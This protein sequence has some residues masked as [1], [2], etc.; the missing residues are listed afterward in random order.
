MERFNM[1]AD[2]YRALLAGLRAAG[3]PGTVELIFGG[4]GDTPS[5]W[6]R[7]LTEV[8]E[9]GG[10]DELLTHPFMILPNAPAAEP[11][12]RAKW[13]LRGVKRRLSH[14][15]GARGLVEFVI[16]SSSY[17]RAEY[18]ELYILGKLLAALH[19]GGLT[20]FVSRYLRE[21]EGV[22]YDD[23][24]AG[25]LEGLF[26]SG[27]G[28]AAGL[29]AEAAGRIRTFVEGGEDA[30]EGFFLRAG[31]RSL[32]ACAEAYFLFELLRGRERFYAEL[33]AFLKARY[34]GAKALESV[35]AWQAS[36]MIGADYQ[37]GR[38]KPLEFDRD[39]PGYFAGSGTRPAPEPLAAPLKLRACDQ[40]L[41]GREAYPLDWQESGE[42]GWAQA[43][44]SGGA[45]GWA[46]RFYFKR[47][48]PA[49]RAR[50]LSGRIR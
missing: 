6:R 36:I 5:G 41:G 3:I 12:Y 2:K 39:W 35:L 33:G 31:G 11:A 8:M 23:F 42:A 1:G 20:L 34:P 13:G 4:P 10:H 25:L 7:S 24:Y 28:L 50:T 18:P 37:R 30:D 16:E 32:R 19:N 48:E 22:S 44:L 43:L 9:W 26:K 40:D 15:P 14:E 29:Y 47:L 17:S 38:G 21:S 46:P 27:G 45:H 49:P